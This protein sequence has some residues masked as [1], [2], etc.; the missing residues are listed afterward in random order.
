MSV[1]LHSP[2]IKRYRPAQDALGEA[3]AAEVLLKILENVLHEFGL[4]ASDLASGTTDSGSDVK[5][6]SVNG[7][8]PKYGVLWNWCC[9]HLM[10]KAAEDAFGTHA[11]PQKSKNPEAR[12]MLKNVI[13]MVGT[14][15]KSPNLTAKFE[16]LQVDLLGE[17]LKIPNQ[18]P[19]RWLTLVRT[20]ERVIRLWHVLRK[21][22]S[23]AGKTFPLE[24]GD[25]KDCILQLYSLLQPLSSVTRDGQYGGAPMMA[26]IYMKFG[27]L[28]MSVLN[29]S[30]DLKVFDIPPLGEDGLPDREQQKK[31]LPHTMVAPDDLHPVAQKARDELCRALVSRFYGRVWDDSCLDPSVLCDAACLLTPPFSEGSYLSAMKLAAEENDYLAAGSSVVAPTT[32]EEVQEKLDGVWAEI[33]KRAITS[34][35]TAQSRAAGDGGEHGT[36]LF[37]RARTGDARSSRRK[38]NEDDFSVFGRNEVAP[39]QNEGDVDLVEEEVSSEIMR[40]KGVFM[41]STDVST[42]TIVTVVS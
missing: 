18:A 27:M 42:T 15:H 20:L 9:C 41:K 21:L 13:G 34:V 10:V 38:N 7:L 14:L 28:K 22:H 33:K 25:N 3:K 24:E 12:K 11:D 36:N 19:Q 8:H 23:D 4:R 1:P 37:K 6:V 39:F 5:S 31:P 29:T 40:Y 26:D 30:A 2:Q 16:D 17:I 32:D 35:K